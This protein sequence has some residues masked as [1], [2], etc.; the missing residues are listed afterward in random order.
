M[1]EISER[2]EIELQNKETDKELKKEIKDAENWGMAYNRVR[3]Q[4]CK[5]KGINVREFERTY[6]TLM[7]IKHVSFKDK[8]WD[9]SE[10]LE[11]GL[12][13]INGVSGVTYISPYQGA[14]E[15]PKYHMNTDLD[16]A[17]LRD[18]VNDY[19]EGLTVSK[20]DNSLYVVVSSVDYLD[21][22]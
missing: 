13:S 1:V 11:V 17:T 21:S 20:R 4:I 15:P 22:N 6:T 7:K 2:F 12:R 8:P 5:D 16:E 9:S 10:E 19:Y 3:S 18:R 14:Y